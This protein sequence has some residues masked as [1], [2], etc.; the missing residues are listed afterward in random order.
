MIIATLRE[1]NDTRVAITP[2]TIK[3]YLKLG[4]TVICEK[5]AGLLAGFAD[6]EYI[7]VGAKIETKT[8]DIL[9]KANILLCVNEPSIKELKE[10]AEESLIIGQ[11]DN[12]KDSELLKAALKN[13]LNIFSMNSVPRITRAQNMDSLSSQSNLAGYRAIIEAAN[14]FKKA[15]PMMMTAAGMIHPAKVLV[16]GAG[17][18]GLQAIA[19]AKR[20]GAEVFAF[21]VRAA[22]KE[23]VESVGGEFIE[24]SGE[25]AENQSGY[26]SET[27]E[28]YKKLQAQLIDEYAQKSDIIIC[29]ALIPNKQAPILI[30][31]QTVKKMKPGSVIIDLATS[32]GGNCEVSQVDKII[33]F[34]NITVIGYQNMPGL[35][36]ATASELYAN[37]LLN[38]V[39]LFAKDNTIQFDG[40]DEIIKN[41]LLTHNGKYLFYMVKENA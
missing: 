1:K 34:H 7:K 10:L 41:A 33:N 38:V 26:A 22:T 11:I 17:V 2:S 23:Q 12:N 30:K 18:A 3:H 21:D 4:L 39:R 37:N 36:P 25:D 35:I 13:N 15:M 27:S 14:H 24:V 8:K 16:L 9:N 6:E 40:E 28:E 29:T 31:E 20:L 5:D 32:R 19:S